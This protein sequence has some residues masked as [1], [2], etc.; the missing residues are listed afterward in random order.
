MIKNKRGLSLVITS[1]IIVLLVLVA[2]GIIW[3]SVKFIIE[4]GTEQ[5]DY[6]SKCLDVDVQ[7]KKVI[8]TT[9][10][11]YSVTFTRTGR[12]EEIAGV[13]I[14]FFN[15][16]DDTSSVINIIGN[17]EPLATITKSVE[18]EIENA[19]KIEVTAYF[20]DESENEKICSHKSSFEF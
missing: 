15:A 7:A 17:I 8:N 10:T 19:N 9:L 13:K 2:L 20:E 14:V 4:R 5:I 16:S 18:G 6:D 12:G 11:N 3:V 1:L